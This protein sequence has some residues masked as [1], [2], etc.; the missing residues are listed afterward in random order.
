MLHDEYKQFLAEHKDSAE[1]TKRGQEVKS[2]AE[3]LKG[4]LIT[5]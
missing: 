4:A 5:R 3:G 1:L 2:M